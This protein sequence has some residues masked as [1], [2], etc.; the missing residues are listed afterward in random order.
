MRW[1]LLLPL[2]VACSSAPAPVA[3][4][5]A[6]PQAW[7]TRLDAEHPL[8]GKIWSVREARFVTEPEM[9]AKLEGRVLLGEKHDNADHHRLQA[10]V[11]GALVKK[12]PVVA[13]EMLEQAQQ[14][15]IDAARKEAPHDA[16]HLATAVAWDKSG[17]P[18]FS[19]YAPVVQAALDA[20]LPIVGTG[21]PRRKPGTPAPALDTGAPLSP[22][23]ERSL[24]E[25]LRES[26]CGKLPEEHLPKMIAMQRA[27]DTAMAK[28][29]VAAPSGVLIA[30]TGHTRKD[31]GAGRDI[32][33]AWS[34]AFAEV[35]RTKP[36][37]AAYASRWNTTKLPFDYVWFTPRANDDDPCAGM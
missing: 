4:S 31:R 25:E 32:P 17:W 10:Q 15:A 30:G 34:V 27:R 37:P 20:D 33:G 36:D 19:L 8:V 7:L 9:L 11:L 35:D 21:I 28:A 16:Q 13:F 29:M 23:D 3:P 14:P 24:T 6:R 1:L 26:H 12:R 5:P 18:A 2:L 22:D